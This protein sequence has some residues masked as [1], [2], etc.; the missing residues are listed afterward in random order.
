MDIKIPIYALF[1]F[2]LML[3]AIAFLP[4]IASHFWEKNRYK[5]LIAMLLGVPTAIWLIYAGFYDHLFH[6]LA[7]DYIPFIILIGS[8]FVITGGIYLEGDLGSKPSMNVRFL[9]VGAILASF[10]GTTGA[11]MLLIRPLIRT[12]AKRE[13]K[14][15]TILFFIAVVANCGGLLTPLGDP[16]L[17]MMYLRGTPFDWFFGFFK[18]WLICNGAIIT[19]YYFIDNYF[20]KKEKPENIAIDKTHHKPLNIIGKRNFTWLFGVVFAVAIINPNNFSFI[21]TAHISSYTR[22]I[23][24]ILMATLS[25]INTKRFIRVANNFKWDPVK[26]VALLFFG[27]FITMVPCMLYLESNASK[28]GASSP[29][30]FYYVS[31]LLSSFLDNTPTAV[32][33]YSLAKGL[34]DLNPEYLLHDFV[35]GIPEMFMYAICTGAVFFGAMTYIGNGPNFMVKAIAEN[36]KI[37]MPNFFAYMYKFSLIIL[38]PVLILIQL[39]FIW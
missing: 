5:F 17:F 16:P 15:H 8:L 13:F 30:A 31:G 26:E 14:T 4:L 24:I 23:V 34:V 36:N 20:W 27:I 29:I 2:F 37:E 25:M 12:N 6:T 7:F 3:S 18:E 33:F 1:P 10:M 11:A 28:L 21:K 39:L 32:T 35:A 22:E 9:S 19:I 38:L